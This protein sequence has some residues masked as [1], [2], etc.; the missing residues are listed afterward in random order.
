MNVTNMSF[1]FSKCHKLREIKGINNFN[2]INVTDMS[3]M[4]QECNELEYLDLF[5]FNTYNVTDMEAMFNNC[6]KLKEI[7]GINNFD[8]TN[9]KNKEKI[10]DGCYNLNKLL[11]SKFNVKIGNN[12]EKHIFVIIKTNDLTIQ[13]LIPCYTSD[14]FTTIEEKLYNKY[15]E[16]KNKQIYFTAN[17]I[18]INRSDTLENNNIKSSANISINYY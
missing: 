14:I 8:L 3:A 6:H 16:L 12:I 11:L 18:T 4:F 17:G 10:F 5:N 13:H 9:V 7:K 15:P 1:M 2:T